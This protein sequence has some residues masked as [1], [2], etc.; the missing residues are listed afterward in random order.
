MFFNVPVLVF[1]IKE[2][3]YYGISLLVS[4][5]G[6]YLMAK[7]YDKNYGSANY[8]PITG[9]TLVSPYAGFFLTIY[10]TSLALYPPFPN[11]ILFLNAILSADTNVLWYIIVAI[12]FFGNFFLAVKV[13]AKTVFGKPNANVHYIDLSILER[14]IHI[15][16]FIALITL[17]ILGLQEVLK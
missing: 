6:L 8:Q 13:M 16:I 15:A 9:I 12:V 2:S 1:G 17:S 4:L 11:S 3:F 7:Y 5:F 10:L 14:S